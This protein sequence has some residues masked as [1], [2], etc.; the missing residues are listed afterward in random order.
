MVDAPG[1]ASI[2]FVRGCQLS[3]KYCYNIDLRDPNQGLEQSDV[4]KLIQNT[5]QEHPQG[6]HYNTV[7]WLIFSGG[8]PLGRFNPGPVNNLDFKNLFTLRIAEAAKK[9]GLKIGYYTTGITDYLPNLFREG[10]IDFINIDYKHMNID[11]ICIQEIPHINA[12]SYLYYLMETIQYLYSA[13]SENQLE[14]LHL[15]TVLCKS[16][17]N[18]EIFQEM[19]KK[20]WTVIPEIPILLKRD[21]SKTLQWVLTSFYNDS[22][23]IPTLGNLTSDEAF[24]EEEIKQLLI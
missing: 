4:L 14:Y 7:D 10:L 15:N 8:D 16:F 20:L 6:G 1:P 22:N 23:N 5:Q 9:I 17:H 11:E 12:E 2:V 13:Y 3:C 21:F 24:S 19:K 18:K